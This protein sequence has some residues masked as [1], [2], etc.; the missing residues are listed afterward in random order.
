MA[1]PALSHEFWI[2]PDNFLPEPDVQVQANIKVGQNFGG[3][4]YSYN[5]SSFARFETRFAGETTPVDGRLGDIPALDLASPGEGLLTVIYET[6]V[7]LLSYTKWEKFVKF[8]THKDFPTTLEDHVSRGIP[9]D[10]RFTESYVRYAKSLI[11]VGH[12]KGSDSEVGLKTEIVALENP[13]RMDDDVFSIKVLLDGAP[14]PDAQVELFEKAPD[15]TVEIVLFRTDEN[16]VA[17]LNIK[18]GYSYLADAVAML[19]HDNDDHNDGP[20]WWSLWASLTFQ[21]PDQPLD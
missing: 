19:P 8:V 7:N 11:A 2:S 13:Y 14:R 3:S 9:K 20:V 12:G 1:G 5:P 17:D 21:V 6:D 10:E 16:G 15:G 18:R 4:S